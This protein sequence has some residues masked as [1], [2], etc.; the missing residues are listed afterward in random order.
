MAAIL[1]CSQISEPLLAPHLKCY[2][3]NHSPGEYTSQ[4]EIVPSH[5]S[6]V[7]LHQYCSSDG[8]AIIFFFIFVAPSAAAAPLA[9]SSLAL[10]K[11]TPHYQTSKQ[12]P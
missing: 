7:V 8:V 4:F 5:S 9:A 2:H 10:L 1:S 12:L 3:N 11:F 6:Y